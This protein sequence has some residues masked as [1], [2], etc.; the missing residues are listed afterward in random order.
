MESKVISFFS[1]KGGVGKTLLSLN[2]AVLLS[3]ENKKVFFLDL[4]LGAPQAVDKLFGV[5][6]KYCLFNL[7]P[8]LGEFKEGKRDFNNYILR[9][10]HNLSFLPSI[11]K[12]AQRNAINEQVV[13]D[14]IYLA[15]REYEYVIVDSGSNLTNNLI[16]IF[17]SSNLI[18]VVLT[19]DIL[20]VYQTQW[21]LDT[22]QSIGFPITMIKVILNRAESQGSI[23]WEEIKAILPSQ[24]V[25]LVPSEGKI[26]GWAINKGVPVVIENP[27]CKIATSLR[28]L[29]K[30]LIEKENM[31]ISHKTLADIRVNKEQIEGEEAFWQ[32][33]GVMEKMETV[34]LEEEEDQIIK[35]KKRVHEKLLEELD[36]KRIPIET[37]TY[38]AQKMKELREKA[39]K[40]VSNVITLEAGGFISSTEVR[41]KITKE[42]IDE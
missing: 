1:T 32:K 10:K 3:Q 26:V 15:S 33:I 22:L 2:L 18:F 37:Y 34:S 17:E 30:E 35:F 39:E 9:Y 36:L 4:D 16:T 12:M 21:L 38:S 11:F 27:S 14:I 41:K 5:N 8:H 24:I 20:S 28:K 42:I 7:I 40:I 23:N 13:K 25:A 29:A 19:P 6:S 31:Y